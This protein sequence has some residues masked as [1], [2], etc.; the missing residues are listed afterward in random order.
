ML[1]YNDFSF[2]LKA[3]NR[4]S[5]SCRS[6][7]SSSHCSRTCRGDGDPPGLVE[8]GRGHEA[9]GEEA[10]GSD[11]GFDDGQPDADGPHTT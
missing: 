2:D 7:P 11:A 9:L 4:S 6:L 3:S 8:H 1:A 5:A 10:G